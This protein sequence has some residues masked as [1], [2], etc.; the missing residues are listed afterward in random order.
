MALV[1]TVAIYLPGL[2]DRVSFGPFMGVSLQVS[3]GV[4]RGRHEAFFTVP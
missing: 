2:V 4:G 3:S 1:I